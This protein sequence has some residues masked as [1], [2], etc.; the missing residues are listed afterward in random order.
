MKKKA[1][2][3]AGDAAI[4]AKFAEW[5]AREDAYGAAILVDDGPH[6]ADLG[7]WADEIATEILRLPASGAEG[8][9]VKTYLQIHRDCALSCPEGESVGANMLVRDL[10]RFAPVLEPRCRAYLDAADA[11]AST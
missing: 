2:P 8:L 10:V 7:D 4:L 3:A 11:E 9:A 5:C 1:Q 6:T